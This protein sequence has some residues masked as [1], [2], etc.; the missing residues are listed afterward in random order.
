MRLALY[1]L[2]I[3]IDTSSTFDSL[4]RYFSDSTYLADAPLPSDSGDDTVKVTFPSG[5]VTTFAADSSALAVG[6][7]VRSASPSFVSI[8]TAAGGHGALLTRFIQVDSVT[9]V[10]VKR[11][12]VSPALLDTYVYP[13]PPPP[14]AGVLA[15]GGTPSQR[16]FLRLSVPS[17]IVDSS[18]I[19]RATLLLFPA[20]PVS[21]APG[22]TVRVLARP[23][24]ADVGPKSPVLS[25]TADTARGGQ[26]RAPPGSTD[27]VRV[28]FTSI[29]RSWKGDT[30][31]AHTVVLSSSPEAGTFAELRFWSSAS[32]AY[33]PLLDLTYVPPIDYQ[34]R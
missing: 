8:K 20:A 7:A 25:A 33:R 19:V 17:R 6:I 15:V 24:T 10:R 9:G 3:N 28:D 13:Q 34:G 26:G 31:R 4:N 21:A 22:D 32:P 18:T 5:L 29:I 23:V 2:P 16:T 30:T 12:M 14:P 1:R 27:T 11:T